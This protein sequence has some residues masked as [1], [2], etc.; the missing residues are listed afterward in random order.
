MVA[1]KIKRTEY[2]DVH[3]KRTH[4]GFNAA[5]VKAAFDGIGMD[6]G[7]YVEAENG[8]MSLRPDQLI[9]VLWKAVQDLRKELDAI[10]SQSA[11]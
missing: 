8:T 2:R 6:F 3:G 10:K 5:E 7:G 9:P 4:W 1:G 11:A